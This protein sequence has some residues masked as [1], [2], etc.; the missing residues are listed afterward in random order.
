MILDIHVTVNWQLSGKDNLLTSVTC[1]YLGL[2]CTTNWGDVSFNYP[3][4]SYW[5]SIDHRLRPFLKEEFS[6]FLTYNKSWITW[7]RHII[8]LKI[9]RGLRFWP[10]SYF[11]YYI[12]GSL[13]FQYCFFILPISF[14]KTYGTTPPGQRISPNPFVVPDLT[15]V[16]CASLRSMSPWYRPST[17]SFS[18]MQNMKNNNCS[19]KYGNISRETVFYISFI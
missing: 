6:L 2:R 7:E 13:L 4:T 8:Y 5:F 9:P 16:C 18:S 10:F 11:V 1:L 14:E 3:L 17:P 15:A 19:N 12:A